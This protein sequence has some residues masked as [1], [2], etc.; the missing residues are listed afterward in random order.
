M[1]Y[2]SMKSL[3]K[4]II[5]NCKAGNYKK[6]GDY[7]VESTDTTDGF[8]YFFNENEWLMIRPSGTETCSKMLCRKPYSR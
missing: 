5:S 4:E 6:F 8:K 2:T 3:K 7:T 1:I